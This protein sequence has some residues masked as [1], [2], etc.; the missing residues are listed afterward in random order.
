MR[1][2]R[3]SEQRRAGAA[4]KAVSAPTGAA[5]KAVSAPTTAPGTAPSA[6][7]QKGTFFPT[8]K[9]DPDERHRRFQPTSTNVH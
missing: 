3:P 6:T 2:Q 9:N 4:H 8:P 5:G 1:G 7:P